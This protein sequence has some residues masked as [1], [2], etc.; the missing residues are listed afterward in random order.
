[1]EYANPTANMGA[2]FVDGKKAL[3][4]YSTPRVY[5]VVDLPKVDLLSFDGRPTAYW[6][7]TRQFQ[8][9]VAKRTSD[10]GQRLLYSLHHFRGKARE[11]IE[12]CVMLSPR[13]RYE[14]PCE[15]LKNL[16]GSL[17]EVAWLLLNGLCEGTKPTRLDADALSGLAVPMESCRIALEQMEYTA[18]LNSLPMLEQMVK[19]LQS[20]LQAK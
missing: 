15:I 9:H 18:D 12:G 17:H 11:A 8:T 10:G 19:E 5:S 3:P 13:A 16:F 7:F 20:F 14:R 4:M 6:K 2:N 1:M